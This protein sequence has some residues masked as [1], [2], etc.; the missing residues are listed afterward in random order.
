MDRRGICLACHQE[1]PDQSLAV[2]FLHHIA[3]AT[4]QVPVRRDQHNDLV[5]K[6]LLATAWGQM[7]APVGGLFVALTAGIWFWRRRR[8]KAAP[9]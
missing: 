8:R 9:A 3:E 6:I 1:I 4:G 7:L 2:S 5:H